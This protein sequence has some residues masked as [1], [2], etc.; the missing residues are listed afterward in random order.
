LVPLA[1]LAEKSCAAPWGAGAPR[2]KI[3]DG[4]GA[5]KADTLARIRADL[6]ADRITP[7]VAELFAHK[8]RRRLSNDDLVADANTGANTIDRWRGGHTPRL[9]TFERAAAAMGL[10]VVLVPIETGG[11]HD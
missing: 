1:S 4:L 8:M 5:R 2:T 7:G 9:A 3:C 10:R 11:G 6:A